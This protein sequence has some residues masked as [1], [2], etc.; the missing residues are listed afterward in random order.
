MSDGLKGGQRKGMGTSNL[1]RPGAALTGGA[2]KVIC[3]AGVAVLVHIIL[4][5]YRNL[6]LECRSLELISCR[7]IGGDRFE[8]FGGFSS[9]DPQTRHIGI[10]L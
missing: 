5:K 8:R 9:E 6:A 2:V 10:N 3:I 1:D 7:F 4:E